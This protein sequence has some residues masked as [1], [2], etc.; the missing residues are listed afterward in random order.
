MKLPSAPVAL[1][2]SLIAAGV[3]VFAVERWVK[4]ERVRR[5]LRLSLSCKILDARH[6]NAFIQRRLRGSHN[7]ESRDL[8]GEGGV[9]RWHELPDRQE[10]L[11]VVCDNQIA[12][13]AICARH[14][15]VVGILYDCPAT[16]NAASEMCVMEHGPEGRVEPLFTPLPFLRENIE[17]I[18]D[19]LQGNKRDCVDVG[20]GVGRDVAF[21]ANRGW[22]VVGID[23]LRKVLDAASSMM[24]RMSITSRVSLLE[25]K[26]MKTGAIKFA[27][28]EVAASALGTKTFGLVIIVRFLERAAWQTLENLVDPKGGFICIC[29]FVLEA[30]GSWP[31]HSPKTNGK[32][33]L[34]GE[35]ADRFSAAR[36][37]K[38]VADEVHRLYDGRP[39]N[40]FL[41]RRVC[42]S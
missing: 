7:I 8:I 5:L 31:H 26:V 1:F 6:R 23:N 35:L 32:I 38:I 29:T 9:A 3:T 14:R 34:P 40:C 39:L 24:E 36:G 27:D 18:E 15:N 30:D 20:C 33:L 19:A 11:L 28:E 42:E 2:G 4:R 17:M 12:A 41:A 25:G 16:W 21:L 10:P 22:H 37:W 13:D